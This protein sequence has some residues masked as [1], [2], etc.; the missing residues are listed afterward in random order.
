MNDPHDPLDELLT[1]RPAPAGEPAWKE[2]LLRQTAGVLRRR[3][4]LRRV[5]AVAA[6]A[7]CFAAGML[8]MRLV[9][10]PA[11]AEV[12]VVVIE[13]PAMLAP[14]PEAVVQAQL[15]KPEQTGL[16]LEWQAVEEPER[17]AELFRRA[18]DRYLTAENDLES[19]VRCY[20]RALDAGS[21]D[22]LKITPQDTWLLISLKNAR[23]EETAHAK[24]D[25]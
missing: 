3:R 15:P 25:S 13:H 18:G 4:R 8:T 14:A 20:R 1:P 6:L 23:Q 11:P 9:T 10:P 16:A 2:S 19:A 12:R 24:N 17:R 7:A 21:A 22:D 5:A